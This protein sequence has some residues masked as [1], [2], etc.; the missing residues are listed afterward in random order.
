MSELNDNNQETPVV[1]NTPENP[2]PSEPMTE[3]GP[4]I[5][6]NGIIDTVSGVEVVKKKKNKF[7]I[8]AIVAC[9]AAVLFG[10]SFAAYA[11][12]PQV[13]NFVKLTFNSPEKYF[14]WVEKENTDEFAKIFDEMDADEASGASNINISFDLN[15]ES[16]NALTGGSLDD[17]L[18]FSIP[19]KFEMNQKSATIDGYITANQNYTIDGKEL[20]NYNLYQK[21]SK[22]YYQ[23]PE[24]SSSYICLDFNQIMSLAMQNVDSENAEIA[25]IMSEIMSGALTGD[26]ILSND[27]IKTLYKRYY[28]I[29]IDNVKT[30]D[31]SK[32]VKCEAGGVSCKLTKL[33]AHIDEGTLFEF[34]KDALKELKNDEIVIKLVTENFGV[35]E[36]DYAAAIDQAIEMVGKYNI[37]GGDE[38]II[39]NVFVDNKGDVVGRTF[40]FVEDD[41]IIC[42]FGYNF[43]SS[44]KNCG[45]N[46]FVEAE[47]KKYFIDGSF[48]NDAGKYTGTINVSDKFEIDVDKFR[49]DE[50]IE[51]DVTL[52]LGNFGTDDITVS[53]SAEDDK[54]LI[55][56]DLNIKGINLGAVSVSADS[57]TPDSMVVFNDQAAVYDMDNI[58]EYLNNINSNAL[59][60]NLCKI[61]G[62]DEAYADTFMQG[63]MQGFS[64]SLNGLSFDDDDF[65][66][67]DIDETDDDYIYDSNDDPYADNTVEYD[68]SKVKIQVDG[69]DVSFPAKLDNITKL[70]DFD[71]ET[72]EPNGF[73][74]GFNED[75]TISASIQNNSDKAAAPKDCEIASLSVSEN[76]PVSLSVDGIKINDDIKKVADKYNC[77]LDNTNS[78]FI[79][80]TDQNTDKYNS[81]TF[82]YMDGKIYEISV[83][84]Y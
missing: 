4:E 81:I 18:G 61:L 27:D 38:M 21:D 74:Y 12:V 24:I 26:E 17:N 59:G 33:S 84:F 40:E 71:D 39:M 55:N 77:T 15:K 16:L 70:I 53:F 28:K 83:S 10:G 60:V 3:S 72:I 49:A 29:L 6:A 66:L 9:A 5:G 45:M 31:R 20:L 42:T 82:Y 56:T 63:F 58:D 22:L 67:S 41:E 19:T 50:F 51:G 46:F 69:K 30:V 25:G 23:I 73:S 68:F 43:T 7:K 76:A 54:Q 13:K 57:Q 37:S 62:I 2:A 47:G 35:S 79:D 44:G 11:F 65:E 36:D 48:K 34:A 80:I 78:G 14:A 52:K 1:T 8:A 64:Q 32:N 75:Y